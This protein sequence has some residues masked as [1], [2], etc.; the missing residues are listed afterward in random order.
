MNYIG[1]Y[2]AELKLKPGSVCDAP[3]TSMGRMSVSGTDTA[4]DPTG[5]AMAHGFMRNRFALARELNC[6]RD[7]SQSEIVL[8]AYHRWNEDFVSRIEG[9]VVCCVMDREKDRLLLSRDRMG[10]CPLF[11]A[12]RGEAFMF[13]DHPDSL[14]KCG[15]LQPVLDRSAACEIFGLGPAR[16][17]GKTFL[18]GM[19]SLRPGHLLILEGG[20]MRIS[21]YYALE[22]RPHEE[23]ERMTVE[24]VRDLL[25]QAVD[26]YVHFHPGCMLSGGLD[27]TALTALLCKRIG[28]VETFS[29]DY[30]GNDAD[31]VAND[32]RPEMDMPYI[33]LAA[34]KFGTIHHRFEL[35]QRELAE[36]LDGA[37]RLRGFPGMGDIDS[38]LMLFARGICRHNP[39]V[40]SGECGD[41]V[42]GGYPW[43][44]R[45]KIA[46]DC[47]PWSGSMELRNSI[48]RKEIRQ[49][50][51]IDDY[52]R[53]TLAQS[54]DSYDV[55]SAEGEDEKRRFKLQRLCFDYFM[56]NLQ[57][58]AARMCEGA[59]LKVF[60]PLCDDRLAEYVY[61]VPWKMKTMGNAEKGL[62]RSAMA[63]LLPEKLL[64]RKKSPYPKTCSPV[65]GN[66]VRN[67]VGEILRDPH[68]P[69][70]QLADRD[71]VEK[72]VS[73][74]LNPA[75]TPWF[76]QLMAGAQLLTYLAQINS[77]MAER[78][79]SVE[80]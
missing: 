15:F 72:L 26:A 24:H 7:A 4:S 25:E 34:K 57:E 33:R 6:P 42:F 44:T 22:A 67:R 9:P 71:F 18:A 29:V 79:V 5:M 1:S 70:W 3:C 37:M 51:C 12:S 41:E 59:G 8:A 46:L 48:L 49:K 20:E 75:D 66:L 78:K 60:T 23:N 10:E 63:D 31:F 47:F 39:S 11:F 16:T 2:H 58:R 69:L 21:A 43:F 32:F 62:F 19:E 68:A 30:E 54:L 50:L 76:G 35:K 28:R 27:S 61:N 56:P 64:W 73:S 77:W 74:D 38:S 80:L 45:E 13:S 55:S 17:P 52:V 40:L 14:L 36:S 65:Y 53:D